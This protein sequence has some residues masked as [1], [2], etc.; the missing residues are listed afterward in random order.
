MDLSLTNL[1]FQNFGKNVPFYYFYLLSNST[2][3]KQ[4]QLNSILGGVEIDFGFLCQKK[5]KKEAR[6]PYLA[7]TR[8]N[9]CLPSNVIF[10]LIFRT[11]SSITCLDLSCLRL[12]AHL[13]LSFCGCG[14]VG[15][16]KSF[17]CPTQLSFSFS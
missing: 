6:N 11:I 15:G 3:N 13:T 4:T 10:H 5:K 8:R 1:G 7:F 9:D 16:L 17:S 14:W 12:G 2:P